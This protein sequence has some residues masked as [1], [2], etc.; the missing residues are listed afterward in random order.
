[1][2]PPG[3]VSGE[4]ATRM[5][6]IVE[7]QADAISSLNEHQRI[8]AAAAL[9]AANQDMKRDALLER[10]ADTLERIDT[11]H[12]EL[13]DKAIQA[14][15]SHTTQAIESSS[16]WPTIWLG[17]LSAAAAVAAAALAVLA[18]RAHP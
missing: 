11:S 13:R 1:M 3:D 18:A 17:I 12:A 4:F 7:K 6:G 15:N 16:K 5:L 9:S 8:N 14:V 10:V 2:T